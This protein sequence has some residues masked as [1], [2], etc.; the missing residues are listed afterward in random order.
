MLNPQ[1]SWHHP[2]CKIMLT[3]AGRF[4]NE[5][6][7]AKADVFFI[8]PTTDVMALRGNANLDNK[9]INRQTD[10]Y[11]IKYQASVFNGSCKVYA[12]RYRQAALHNFFTKI[13]DRAQDAFDTAYSDIKIWFLNII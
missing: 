4:K 8:H 11:T 5:Q 10:N 9:A 13:I 7:T 2:P 3:D 6:A 12:P 1:N